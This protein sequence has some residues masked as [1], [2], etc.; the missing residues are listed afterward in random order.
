[1]TKT[2]YWLPIIISKK[3]TFM[4][5]SSMQI[6]INGPVM[7]RFKFVARFG[8]FF[9]NHIHIFINEKKNIERVITN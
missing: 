3:L 6:Y 1:M 4:P 8:Q 5:S 7:R 9:K 2:K